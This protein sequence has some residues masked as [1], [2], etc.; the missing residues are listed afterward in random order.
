MKFFQRLK[1]F[2][3]RIFVDYNFINHL[4]EENSKKYLGQVSQ[5]NN[6]IENQLQI[7]NNKIDE[8]NQNIQLQ[9]NYEINSKMNNEIV[10][11]SK[12]VRQFKYNNTELQNIKNNNQKKNVLIIGFYGAP[13]LGDELMLET[14]L[15]YLEY[16]TSMQITVLL[17]DNPQ[18]NIDKFKDI[19][20]IHYPKT[21]YDFNILAEQYD[22]FIFGGGAIIN[23]KNF[24]KEDSYQ[25][26]LGTILIKLSLRAIAFKKKVIC[27][28]LSSSN[29]IT[30]RKYIEKLKYIVE[31]SFYF[32]V[33]DVYTKKLLVDQMGK[34]CQEKIIEISDIVFANRKLNDI[35][36]RNKP[37]VEILNIGIIW[38][39]NDNNV[40]K[41]EDTLK[42]IEECLI[43][44]NIEK[45]NINLIPFYEYCSIDTKFYN[46]IEQTK[47]ERLIL[48]IEKYPEDINETINVFIKNDMII[49]MRYHSV[50]IAHIL[51]IPCVSICY[52]IHEEYYNKIK[53]LNQ[54]FNKQEAL[55]YM[56]MNSEEFT[57]RI[58]Q[59]IDNN[60]D[61]FDIEKS[62]Q[63]GTLA[64]EQM[65]E[66]I[67]K[68]FN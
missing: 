6:N 29:K 62:K 23:D 7:I 9:K 13:N 52:D 26:D 10:E 51:A 24:E 32:S 43:N 38:I 27:L 67:R 4:I 60:K 22:Y 15:E 25:Y 36:E 45:C 48:N 40:Q 42:K 65:E 46:K 49:G 41:L 18:Y 19:R 57:K 31:N 50:L 56:Q 37:E 55:S 20:F 47:Y 61:E 35:I 39:A 17:A 63:I 12:V 44:L 66:V 53:H 5:T 54:L 64:K 34:E 68:I 11:I 16:D 33:R 1:N 2:I 30:N 21:L 8:L 28:A 58:S 14:L 3:R 59:I